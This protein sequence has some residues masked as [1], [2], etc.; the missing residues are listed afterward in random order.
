MKSFCCNDP[1]LYSLFSAVETVQVYY[2]TPNRKIYKSHELKSIEEWNAM[3]IE[4]RLVTPTNVPFLLIDNVLCPNLLDSIE[5][6][7]NANEKRATIHSHAGKNRHHVHPNRDLE[8][9]IDNKLSR[10]LFPEIMKVFYF[11]V[12]YREN[13]KICRYNAETGG[14]FTPIVIRPIHFSI[15]VLR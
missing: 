5:N 3:E 8:M 2:L 14:A 9:K 15:D 6:F 4:R 11:D 10:S 1:M 12:K 7:Y 13:Y